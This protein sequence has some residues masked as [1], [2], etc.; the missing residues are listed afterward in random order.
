MEKPAVALAAESLVDLPGA[1]LVGPTI[2][3]EE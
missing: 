3:T 2:S 1:S